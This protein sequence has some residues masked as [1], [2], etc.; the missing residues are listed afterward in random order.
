MANLITFKSFLKNKLV[1]K[2]QASENCDQN[3]NLITNS[4]Q[5]KIIVKT[6]IENE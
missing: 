6:Q 2:F 4:E 1:C 5:G 3:A